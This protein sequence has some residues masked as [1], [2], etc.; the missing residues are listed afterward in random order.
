MPYANPHA[1][2]PEKWKILF[3]GFDS[4]TTIAALKNYWIYSMNVSANG[5]ADHFD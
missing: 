5:T 1:I 4:P 3:N 2:D